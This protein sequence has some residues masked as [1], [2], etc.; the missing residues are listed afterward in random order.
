[1]V[2]V[3]LRL[4]S[5]LR[6]AG[7]GFRCFA[8]VTMCVGA[9]RWHNSPSSPVNIC[10]LASLLKWPPP[11]FSLPCLAV[12][13]LP[14]FNDS[15][16]HSHRGM[17]ITRWSLTSERNWTLYWR[18]LR[19]ETRKIQTVSASELCSGLR[20]RAFRRTCGRYHPKAMCRLELHSSSDE[21]KK[22]KGGRE[23][24]GSYSTN[25]R[26]NTPT[27]HIKMDSQAGPP[28]ASLEGLLCFH[29]GGVSSK[30]CQNTPKGMRN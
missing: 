29:L 25:H 6:L 8:S 20:T 1:M 5:W 3:V 13:L 24:G 18:S 12:F 23:V 4:S 21:E 9:P 26:S 19:S 27:E 15:P 7:P 30:V 28:Q 2:L 16:L 22:D 14:F 10:F 11:C 17:V